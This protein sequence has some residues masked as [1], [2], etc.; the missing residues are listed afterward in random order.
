[1]VLAV[2]WWITNSPVFSARNVEVTGGSRLTRAEILRI[3]GVGPGTNLFWLRVGT[4][5]HRLL[6]DR[7]IVAANVSRSLPDTLR[8]AI[9]E[10]RPVAQIKDS[11]G[12]LVV[13]GDGTVLRRRRTAAGLPMLTPDPQD[14]QALRHLRQP[15]SIVAWMNPWL[16]SR[17]VSVQ[18]TSTGG[19]VVHLTPG[20]PA[21]YGDPTQGQQKD[22]A[23]EA[24]LKWALAGQQPLRSIDVQA[25]VAPTARLNVYIPPVKVPSPS[26]SPHGRS[27]S[28]SAKG[29]PSPSPS[30]SVPAHSSSQHGT[31][32]P[33]TH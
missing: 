8:I 28:P 10:R 27:R 17:V 6:R 29:S 7:W 25:P 12:F 20:I 14:P 5:E 4:A 3:A 15:A 18:Q 21:Y 2:G 22:Q 33:R 16:R 9:R 32:K 13:A 1:V 30:P 19:I 31:T 26:P 24:V 23:V 11:R